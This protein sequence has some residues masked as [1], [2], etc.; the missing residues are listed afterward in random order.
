[1]TFNLIKDK[2]LRYK[3]PAISTLAIA[4]FYILMKNL[5]LKSI[6]TFISSMPITIIVT[7]SAL[8]LVTQISMA[9]QWHRLAKVLGHESS[10]AI[11]VVSNAYGG[12]YDSITP[13]SKVGGEL[14]R[15]SFLKREMN[16]STSD[17]S[18]LVLIQKSFSIISLV[19]LGIGSSLPA[20]RILGIPEEKLLIA[21]LCLMLII[22]I[23]FMGL[24]Y[25]PSI[26]GLKRFANPKI[27]LFSFLKGW[28]E[29]LKSNIAVLK[30]KRAEVLLQ[31]ALSLFIWSLF[32]IKL[33]IILSSFADIGLSIVVPIVF[34]SY[35]MGMIPVTPGGLGSFEGTMSSLLIMVGVDLSASI[36]ISVIFRFITFWLVVLVHSFIILV[37]K[38]NNLWENVTV[39]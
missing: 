2:A 14:A 35:F 34:M 4:F 32:P 5:D 26:P 31:L 29:S 11:M 7:V 30:A 16:L 3:N 6:Q 10:M 23:T 21:F 24:R 8:Q 19:L 9:Y 20:Y 17:S 1:M 15:V 38:L 25:R 22:I 33:H 28:L 27:H 39:G 37:W 12:F 18:S 13:G 36:A